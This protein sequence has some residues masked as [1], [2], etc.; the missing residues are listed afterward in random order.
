M[1]LLLD[2]FT[3][4]E[5]VASLFEN[6]GLEAVDSRN[7]H[8]ALEI[9]WWESND[10]RL[11]RYIEDRLLSVRYLLL[12]GDHP[13]RLEDELTKQLSFVKRAD[14][15]RDLTLA[16]KREE[17]IIALYRL[18]AFASASFDK[19][20]FEYFERAFVHPE[21]DVRFAAVFA[22]TYPGWREFRP[23]LERLSLLDSSADVRNIAEMTLAAFALNR[24]RDE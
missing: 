22:M 19:E 4:L 16:V 6:L 14:I 18:A 13:E 21:P 17:W 24:W 2:D 10:S 23:I 15:L 11:V 5:Q 9:L 1:R 3:S 20:L 7:T 12:E 8:Q